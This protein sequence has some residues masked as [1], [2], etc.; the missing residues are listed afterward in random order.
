MSSRLYHIREYEAVVQPDGSYLHEDGDV[1][2]YSEVGDIHREDGPSIISPDGD[3][4]W[5][6]NNIVYTFNDWLKLTP[7]SD[8]EKMLLRLQYE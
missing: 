1:C 3:V 4:E 6:L 2:W 8:E 5:C 7:I